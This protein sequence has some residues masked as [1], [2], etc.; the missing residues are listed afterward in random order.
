MVGSLA[1]EHCRAERR[2]LGL[3]HLTAIPYVPAAICQR[4]SSS[5]EAGTPLTFDSWQEFPAMRPT[6]LPPRTIIAMRDTFSKNGH[7][8]DKR[9]RSSLFVLCVYLDLMLEENV[10][11][12]RVKPGLLYWCIYTAILSCT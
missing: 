7:I 12:C 10:G 5:G 8:H 4:R 1:V 3:H 6:C 11:T 9:G 2:L